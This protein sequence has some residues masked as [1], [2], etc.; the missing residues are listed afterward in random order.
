MTHYPL[1]VFYALED[2]SPWFI[3]A[4]AIGNSGSA[5]LGP[6]SADG[7]GRG[8]GVDLTQHQGFDTRDRSKDE[9]YANASERREAYD[10]EAD[11]LQ[12]VWSVALRL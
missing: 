7:A 2:R 4:F 3:L 6:R 9:Q 1:L 11:D 10:D 12:S 5:P 8:S